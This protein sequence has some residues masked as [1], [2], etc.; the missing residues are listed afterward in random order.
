MLVGPALAFLRAR[1][2]DEPGGLTAAQALIAFRLHGATA[3]AAAVRD[4]ARLDGRRARRSSSARLTVAWA[5]LATGPDA[6]LDPLR[7][8]R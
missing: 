5:A 1:W 3:D 6:L 4:A 8:R 7:S 2:R